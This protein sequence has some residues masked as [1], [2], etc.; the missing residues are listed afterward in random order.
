[1]P[2]KE[3]SNTNQCKISC[4]QRD[5]QHGFMVPVPPRL[6]YFDFILYNI[7]EISDDELNTLY[8]S[9]WAEINDRKP[10]VEDQSE[11]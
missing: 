11:S 7:P 4:S 6:N 8:Y 1:M 3:C 5:V 2:C 10:K 9:V